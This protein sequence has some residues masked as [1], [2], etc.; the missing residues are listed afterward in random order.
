MLQKKPDIASDHPQGISAPSF[1]TVPL[2]VVGEG[3]LNHSNIEAV[4]NKRQPV[5]CP[6]KTK[7]K[8]NDNEAK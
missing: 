7:H 2:W 6:R 5:Y 1:R 8:H 3:F 4:P